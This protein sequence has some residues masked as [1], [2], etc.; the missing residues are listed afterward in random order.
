MYT[1]VMARVRRIAGPAAAIWLV[2]QTAT[3]VLVPAFFIAGSQAA[4]LEC[5]C[6][7]DGN[8][9]DCPMHHASPMGARICIQTTDSTGFAVLG[10]MLGHLGVVPSSIQML[11]L[12]PPPFAERTAAL[13]HPRT[14]APPNPP[15]PR[16]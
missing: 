12:T 15:P 3:L 11:H 6:M 14:P 8:H 1:D 9:R 5:T 13:P 4:P 2:V 10:S 16:A 7:H